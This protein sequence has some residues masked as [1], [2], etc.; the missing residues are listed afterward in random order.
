MPDIRK[1]TVVP[2]AVLGGTGVAFPYPSPGSVSGAI[3]VHDPAMTKTSGGYYYLFTS[4]GL[5]SRA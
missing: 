4:R 2:T 5:C 3:F 1:A